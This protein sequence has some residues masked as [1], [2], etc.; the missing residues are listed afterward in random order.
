MALVIKIGSLRYA[1][2]NFHSFYLSSSMIIVCAF[3]MS[4]FWNKPIEIKIDEALWFWKT[5]LNVGVVIVGYTKFSISKDCI[6]DRIFRC[7]VE[8]TYYT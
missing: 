2:Q 1:K 6:L 8:F 4:T 7:L 3:W 5:N